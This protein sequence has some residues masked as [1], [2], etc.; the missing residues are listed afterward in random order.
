MCE[1]SK[2]FLLPLKQWIVGA[3]E[4]KKRLGINITIREYADD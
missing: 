4:R 2:T 3:G 1:F